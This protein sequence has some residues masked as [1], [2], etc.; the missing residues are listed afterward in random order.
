MCVS[1]KRIVTEEDLARI[2]KASRKGAGVSRAQAA[3]DMGVAQVSIFRAEENP[4]E[5]LLKL[6]IRLIEKYSPFKVEGPMF[7]LRK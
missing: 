3:R 5:S 7:L 2:A 6:R 4:T 1:S